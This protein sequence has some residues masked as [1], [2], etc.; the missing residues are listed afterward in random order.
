MEIIVDVYVSIKYI[1]IR[2][3][4]ILFKKKDER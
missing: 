3:K 4:F 1:K 2:N